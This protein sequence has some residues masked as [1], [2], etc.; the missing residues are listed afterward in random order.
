MKSNL[1]PSLLAAALVGALVAFLTTT[2][3]APGSG[4]VSA[5]RGAPE[6]PRPGVARAADSGP[7]A[8]RLAELEHQNDDLLL[9]IAALENRPAG[10]ALARSPVED[11]ETAALRANSAEL[12]SLLTSFQGDAPVSDAFLARVGEAIE[13]IEA[14]EERQ[15]TEE[16][17]Q[18]AAERMEERLSELRVELGL[19]QYQVDEMRKVLSSAETQRTELWAAMRD[20]GG[21][22]GSVRDQMREIRETSNSAL[23]EVLDQDQYER[24]QETDRDRFGGFGRGGGDRGGGGGGGDRGGGGGGGGR[25]GDG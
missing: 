14:E 2:F 25:R 3:L 24:Y 7:L 10:E 9:R 11:G 17:E 21:D 16:R 4:G 18:Q 13:H 6:D 1:I 22:R 23:S 20:G 5:R 19:S 12:E 8:Q 15:R